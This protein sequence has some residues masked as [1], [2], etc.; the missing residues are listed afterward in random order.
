MNGGTGVKKEKGGGK[1][2][3]ENGKICPKDGTTGLNPGIVEYGQEYC[4][5]L[6]ES[7][8]SSYKITYFRNGCGVGKYF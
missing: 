4:S 6:S 8:I 5:F 3:T 1:T 7:I 2:A